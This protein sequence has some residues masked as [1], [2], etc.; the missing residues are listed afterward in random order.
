MNACREES[1]VLVCRD[2]TELVTDFLEDALPWHKRM[3]MRYHLAICSFCR[4]HLMQVRAT[5]GLLRKLPPVAVSVADE[6]RMVAQLQGGA[7]RPS[8]PF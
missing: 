5:V 1:N 2:V 6:D 7:E 3:A 8:P 4:R